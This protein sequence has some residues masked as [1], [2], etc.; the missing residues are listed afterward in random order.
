MIL[1]CIISQNSIDMSPI[2]IFSFY[3]R[4]VRFYGNLKMTV[5]LSS[6]LFPSPGNLVQKI[7]LAPCKEK[8]LKH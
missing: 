1:I 4:K 2:E 6:T 5:L 8:F 3:N 7:R